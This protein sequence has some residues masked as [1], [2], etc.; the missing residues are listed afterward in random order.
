MLIPVGGIAGFVLM[1]I[2][3]MYWCNYNFELHE[4]QTGPSE[5]GSFGGLGQAI[6]ALIAMALLGWIGSGLGAWLVA[7]YWVG[8]F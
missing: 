3:A 2:A 8:G 6:I 5:A 4:R 1:A 7:R